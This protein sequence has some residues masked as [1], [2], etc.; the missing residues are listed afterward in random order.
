MPR[1]A[2]SS[3]S[4]GAIS[5]TR[6]GLICI[7][8]RRRRRSPRKSCCCSSGVATM[9]G[10]NATTTASRR[11]WCLLRNMGAMAARPSARARASALR[12]RRS[13]PIGRPMAWRCTTSS[14]SRPIIAMACSSPFTARGI[15]RLTRRAATTWYSKPCRVITRRDGCEVF[16]DGFAGAQES[17][18][19]AAHRPSGVA[20]GPDGALFVSDDVRGR[21]YRIVYRGGSGAEAETAFTPCPSASAPAGQIS[22]DEAKPPEGTHPDAGNAAATAGLPAP[23]GAT[24][25]MVALGDRIFHGQVGGATCT[26]CHGA[27]AKGTPLGPNLTDTAMVVGRWQLRVD[28]EDHHQ[29]GTATQTIS[30][31]HAPHGW[32]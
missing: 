11:N 22:V 20:V 21:I 6:T 29:R 26:G 32:R 1:A 12:S 3:R 31:A 16:A 28:R 14:S 5:C 2:S 17:P 18:G 8:P 7:D 24:P 27:D 25:Q 10:R 30:L 4:T 19:G 23:A 9:G 15:G 13:R